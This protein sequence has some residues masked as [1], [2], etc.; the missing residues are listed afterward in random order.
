MVHP[1]PAWAGRADRR[2]RGSVARWPMASRAEVALSTATRR[3]SQIR[4]LVIGRK[5][6]LR[7]VSL[8]ECLR[9]SAHRTP[10]PGE[11]PHRHAATPGPAPWTPAAPPPANQHHR[12]RLDT[13]PPPPRFPHPK[14]GLLMQAI[15]RKSLSRKTTRFVSH[16]KQ[17]PRVNHPPTLTCEDFCM[18]R[19]NL[20][21]LN[22]LDNPEWTLGILNLKECSEFATNALNSARR[23]RFRSI[24]Y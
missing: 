5:P 8:G 2:A 17:C 24:A 16:S 12:R 18:F 11:P 22:T 23:A 1:P 19:P 10:R 15:P 3:H 4:Q 6:P 7:Q 9:V 20:G 14:V 21:L 13:P